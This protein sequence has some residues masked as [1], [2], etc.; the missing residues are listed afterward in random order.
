MMD[1]FLLVHYNYF[2]LMKTY[3]NYLIILVLLLINLLLLI[4][5]IMINEK[6]LTYSFYF[7]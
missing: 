3:L 5:I 6:L 2:F 7:F 4:S 1:T